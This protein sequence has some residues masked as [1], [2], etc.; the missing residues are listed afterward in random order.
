MSRRLPPLAA[1]VAWALAGPALA[2]PVAPSAFCGTYPEAPVCADGPALCETCHTAPP[3][4]NVYGLQIEQALL[5]H[6]DRPF[7]DAKFLENLPAALAAV[8]GL[9]ADADGYPNLD[10]VLAGTSPADRRSRPAAGDCPRDIALNGW[11]VCNY[12]VAYVFKKIMLDFC[13]RSATRD[14]IKAFAAEADALAA[15]H[16]T[17]DACLDTENWRGRDGVVWN[18]ANSKIRPLQSIKSGEDNPGDIPLADYL[19]DYNLF[20]Y[21]HTDDRDVRAVLTAD[22]FVERQGGRN[23]SPTY[24]APFQRTFEQDLAVR[25]I[26]GVQV[27]DREHRA[28]M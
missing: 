27:V 2:R 25:G 11:D 8:E 20:V 15:L 19:D 7:D 1:L 18:M 12:D 17:L 24:Y 6:I 9:D 13:G 14:E 26:G 3:S 10:E 21:A 4:R 5:D 16:E 28:G 22:Y 23:G